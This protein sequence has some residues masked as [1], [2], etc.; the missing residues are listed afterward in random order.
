MKQLVAANQAETPQVTI[1]SEKI[2]TSSTPAW[3]QKEHASTCGQSQVLGEPTDVREPISDQTE[4]YGDLKEIKRHIKETM[5]IIK[6]T[7]E[8][9]VLVDPIEKFESVEPTT[10]RTCCPYYTCHDGVCCAC[11]TCCACWTRWPIAIVESFGSVHPIQLDRVRSER[12][13]TKRKE[14]YYVKSVVFK[15][16]HVCRLREYK[17]QQEN[18]IENKKAKR[19]LIFIPHEGT[20]SAKQTREI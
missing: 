20:S 10:V 7:P 9:I 6:E 18:Q 8:P 16:K 3:V 5:E 2:T 1:G 17:N 12:L 19:R 15:Q 14:S 13:R 4:E 11:C